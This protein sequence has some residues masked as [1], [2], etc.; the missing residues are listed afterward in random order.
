MKAP[1]LDKAYRGQCAAVK[2][3]RT[4]AVGRR[5]RGLAQCRTA[6]G[7]RDRRSARRPG[8][9]PDRD[10][11]SGPRRGAIT[12]RHL[13]PFIGADPNTQWLD[14]C[15]ALDGTGIFA[16]GDARTGSTKRVAAVIAQIQ[17]SLAPRAAA[18]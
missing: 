17:S 18:L 4:N 16:I 9:R 15:A 10:E 6:C 14:G 8:D 5:N 11:V 3:H 2:V 13:F 7:Q 12:S 1:M